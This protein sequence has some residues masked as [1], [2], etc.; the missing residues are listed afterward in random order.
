M[1]KS[2]ELSEE[3]IS[4]INAVGV[5]IGLKFASTARMLIL[6]RLLQIEDENAPLE[7]TAAAAGR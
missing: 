4:R 7:A 3:D 2:I 1:Q 6:E 5:P